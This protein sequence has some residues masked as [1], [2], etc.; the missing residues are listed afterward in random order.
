[1]CEEN[2]SCGIILHWVTLTAELQFVSSALLEIHEVEL[3]L[4][5]NTSN[6]ITHLKA[7]H[8]KEYDAL[9]TA[10]AEAALVKKG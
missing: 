5:L 7:Q 8:E 4:K 3:L 9:V 2:V 10:K 6:L 1:M